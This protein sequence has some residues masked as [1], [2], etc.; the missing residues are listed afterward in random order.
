MVPT[1]SF[2]LLY[3]LLVVCIITPEIRRLIRQVS[4]ANPLWGAPRIH[5]E[6]LTIEAIPRRHDLGGT[7]SSLAMEGAFA[8]PC[9]SQRRSGQYRCRASTCSI[10]SIDLFVVPTISFRLLYGLLVL[11]HEGAFCGWVSR[12]IPPQN[13]SY[14]KSR[15]HVV[16]SAFH[17]I[18][19]VIGTMSTVR[20]LRA[21]F[22]RWTFATDRQR[23]DR[24]DRTAMPN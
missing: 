14:D 18:S 24:L 5:G 4:L 17:N 9:T 3:G 23:H 13:G 16:G 15:R 10:A 22:E 20:R 12:C 1:I 7:F 8:V 19:S 11:R 6:L 2:R 21:A